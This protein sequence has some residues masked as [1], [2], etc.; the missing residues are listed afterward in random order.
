M[1]SVIH[2]AQYPQVIQPDLFRKSAVWF[3]GLFTG[4]DNVTMCY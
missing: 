1:I 3:R 4:A 2:K